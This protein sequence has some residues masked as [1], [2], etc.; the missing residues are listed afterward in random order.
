[1]Q[2]NVKSNIS[3]VTK[4][5][6]AFG[7]NQMPFATSRALNDTAFS[8]R[9]HIVDTTYPKSFQ[10]KNPRF[11]SAMFR[12]GKS[13]K[14]KLV[15][16]VFDRFGKDYMVNQAEGGMKEKRGRYT[17]IPAQDRPAIRGRAGYERNKPRTVLGKP[18]VFVQNV[19]GQDMILERR[20]KKPYPLKRLYLLEEKNIRIPKRFPFYE[21]GNAVA[22]RDFSRAFRKRFAEAKRTARRR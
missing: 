13:T 18:K 8:V 10:V 2:I 15:A 12:V 17:A 5:I 19:G 20:T 9:K 11:A 7:K 14:R 22:Q 16:S 3:A 1:M 4:A 21:Q 6:D